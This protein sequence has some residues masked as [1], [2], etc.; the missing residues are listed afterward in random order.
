MARSFG[1]ASLVMPSFELL[2]WEDARRLVNDEL[3]NGAVVDAEIEEDVQRLA[4]ST[5]RDR[6]SSS[7][8]SR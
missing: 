2:M 8:S 4:V 1:V 5:A 6:I 3:L 7:P